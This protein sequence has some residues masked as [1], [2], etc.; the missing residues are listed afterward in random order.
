VT[1]WTGDTNILSPLCWWLWKCIT[2]NLV[3][4]CTCQPVPENVRAHPQIYW[5]SMLVTPQNS[6][7]ELTSAHVCCEWGF[8]TPFRVQ[9]ASHSIWD[10]HTEVSDDS[11]PLIY[12]SVP[13]SDWPPTFRR[14]V[15]SSSIA[16][17]QSVLHYLDFLTFKDVSNFSSKR[18]KPLTKR[19]NITFQ[20][21]SIL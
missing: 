1:K 20:E 18:L 5:K 14:N 21:K 3:I 12:D 15:F 11:V 13:L 10:L 16:V 4:N 6:R 8:I 17:K 19:Q 2:Q 7:F 9:P